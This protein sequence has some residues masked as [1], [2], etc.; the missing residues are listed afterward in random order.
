MVIDSKSGETLKIAIMTIIRRFSMEKSITM[1]MANMYIMM[2][3]ERFSS[4]RIID[5][6]MKNTLNNKRECGMNKIS[7]GEGS[8]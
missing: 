6:L 2:I 8:I 7:I 1:K 3:T 4:F 5:P